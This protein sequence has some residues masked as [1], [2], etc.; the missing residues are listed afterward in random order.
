MIFSTS[1][2][3]GLIEIETASSGGSECLL[4]LGCEEQSLGELLAW[5]TGTIA[6]PLV[7]DHA[8]PTAVAGP[9]HRLSGLVAAG[10]VS[11][12][13]AD[14]EQLE[15]DLVDAAAQ[16]RLRLTALTSAD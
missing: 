3:V 5:L 7:G 1:Q 15:T 11:V 13:N 12:V 4:P 6:R 16:I 10:P 8:D 2:I 14:F 9:N